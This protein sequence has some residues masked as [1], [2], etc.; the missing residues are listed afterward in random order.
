MRA[1]R[2]LFL[3]KLGFWAGTIAF[4]KVVKRL[5]PSRGDTGSNRLDLVAV[6]DGVALR[7][8]AQAFRGGSA[9]AW[10][11]GIALDLREAQLAENA[12]LELGSVLGGIAVRVPPEWRVASDVRSFA[13]GVAVDVPAPAEHDAPTLH[14]SGFSVLGGIAV[15]A[16]YVED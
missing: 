4:A 5:F 13:G 2:A 15:G 8:S 3:F 14:V 9:F 6:L 10:L 12:R 1:L 11:G 7:S 16:K